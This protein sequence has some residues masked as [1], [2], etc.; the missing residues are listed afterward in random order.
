M[1]T[2]FNL[3]IQVDLEH[4][5]ATAE[6]P[7]HDIIKVTLGEVQLSTSGPGG[8]AV[9]TVVVMGA[10]GDMTPKN[11]EEFQKQLKLAAH[12]S[13]LGSLRGIAFRVKNPGMAEI[14]DKMRDQWSG[15]PKDF[16][17]G[18]LG[19]PYEEPKPDTYAVNDRVMAVEK[20]GGVPR[21]GT[22]VHLWYNGTPPQCT[23]HALD[24]RFDNGGHGV[25]APADIQSRLTCADCG[26]P[27]FETP[28]G[29]C[30]ANGHGGAPSKETTS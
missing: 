3:N 9:Q 4:T 26:L 22:V 18:P 24:I 21:P 14:I 2:S 5:A 30:C 12:S 23:C 19:K 8:I 17:E 11:F 28:G 13:V 25:M 16:Y 7:E 6:K 20:M 15:I 10:V 27:Q 1:N 29:P